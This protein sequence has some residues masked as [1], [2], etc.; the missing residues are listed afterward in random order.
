LAGTD[1]I[2]ILQ[3]LREPA[4]RTPY[5]FDLN[6]PEKKR[7]EVTGVNGPKRRDSGGFN[8]ENTHRL[9]AATEQQQERAAE[10]RKHKR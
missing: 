10:G 6:N 5:D 2:S 3:P 7:R 4:G 1:F 9:S 8:E